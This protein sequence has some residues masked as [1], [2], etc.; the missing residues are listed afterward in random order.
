MPHVLIVDDELNIRRVTARGRSLSFTVEPK[1]LSIGL[2]RAYS[3]GDTVVLA[4]DYSCTPKRGL[5]FTQPDSGASRKPWI[6]WTQGEDMDNHFWFPCY[7]FPNDKS[8]S[9]VTGT[10]RASYVFVSNGRLVSVKEDRARGTR[11]WH[12]SQDLPHSSYLIMLAAGNYAVLHDRAGTVPLDYYVYPGQEENAR[13]CFAE[14]PAIMKF[15]TEKI[16]TPFPWAKYAQIELTDFMYGGLNYQIEHHLFP[17]ICS[18]HFP[19]IREIV[20]DVT[21]EREAD[22]ESLMAVGAGDLAGPLFDDVIDPHAL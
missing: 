12:W 11:T 5:Y 6:I 20:R 4:I 16:A 15:F 8:T 9:E 21:R 17:R 18:V 10:V 19:A 22:V 7:D 1:T 14:T 3:P 2:D 13:A